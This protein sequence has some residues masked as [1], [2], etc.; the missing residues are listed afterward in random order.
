MDGA[1]SNEQNVIEFSADGLM[2][3]PGPNVPFDGLAKGEEQSDLT[4]RSTRTR[5]VRGAPVSATR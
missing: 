5:C 1:P 3:Q 2:Q 4:T